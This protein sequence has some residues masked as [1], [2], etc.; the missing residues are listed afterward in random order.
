MEVLD[1]RTRRVAGVI[2]RSYVELRETKATQVRVDAVTGSAVQ[3][4]PHLVRHDEQHQSDYYWFVNV[5]EGKRAWY[6]CVK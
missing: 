4:R 2:I 1:A 3:G 6:A 5:N